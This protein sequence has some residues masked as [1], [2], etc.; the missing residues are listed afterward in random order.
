MEINDLR[1]FERMAIC[2]K[3]ESAS[4]SNRLLTLVSSFIEFMQKLSL[5]LN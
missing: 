4:I 5:W 2:L 1:D 3:Q